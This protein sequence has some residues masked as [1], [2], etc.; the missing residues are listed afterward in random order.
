M[1]SLPFLAAA[2]IAPGTAFT[3]RTAAALLAVFSTFLL[4][5]PLVVL[6]RI[7]SDRSRLETANQRLTAKRSL[8][9]CLGG[10]AISGT[11]LLRTLPLVWV[12]LLGACGL[13]LVIGSVA[14]AVERSQREITSQMLGVTGLTGSCLPAYLAV[15]GDLDW[16]AP[17]IWALSATHSL[18]SVF[19][20][21]ARLEAILSQRRVAAGP[22]LG[23]FFGRAVGWQ[24]GLW[25]ILVAMAL[26]GY[27]WLALPFLLPS[28]LHGWELWQL[29]SGN[30]VQ[31]SMRRLGWIQLA[32]SVLFFSLLVLVFR[33][34]F[35][36]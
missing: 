14:I 18:T 17:T 34:N 20:V 36:P 27:P 25:T 19:V 21:R 22:P 32:A 6:R 1:V 30:G 11:I 28:T 33:S 4:R 5:D 12:L 29:R 15:R 16:L 24:V 35:I 8:C 7:H 9:F 13:V 10:L 2:A 26:L 3:L 23:R 31:L